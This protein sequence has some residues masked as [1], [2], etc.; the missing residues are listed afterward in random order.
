MKELGFPYLNIYVLNGSFFHIV[1]NKPLIKPGYLLCLVRTMTVVP[2]Q[3]G[4]IASFQNSVQNS[5]GFC[6]YVF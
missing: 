3:N 4:Q 6:K 1:L 2:N 5:F